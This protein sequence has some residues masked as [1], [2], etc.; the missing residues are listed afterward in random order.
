MVMQFVPNHSSDKHEWFKERTEEF[1]VRVPKTTESSWA[2]Q[3]TL[4]KTGSA[5]SQDPYFPDKKYLH[6][7]RENQPDLNLRSEIVINELNV[8]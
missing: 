4:N 3:L 2:S 7:F 8:S 1:Y 5:W 6:Q